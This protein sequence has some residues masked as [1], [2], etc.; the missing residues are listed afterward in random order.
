MLRSECGAAADSKE[1]NIREIKWRP[2]DRRT[3]GRAK[4]IKMEKV[5]QE[6]VSIIGTGFRLEERG[7]R[8]E[9]GQIPVSVW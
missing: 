4:R 5:K 8:D 9:C 3:S 1:E 6:D 7:V 2:A